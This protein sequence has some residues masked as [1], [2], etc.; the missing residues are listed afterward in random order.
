[1]PELRGTTE[2]RIVPLQGPLSTAWPP[3]CVTRKCSWQGEPSDGSSPYLWCAGD[4]A[5]HVR[6]P[7]GARFRTTAPAAAPVSVL[8]RPV[9]KATGL[10]RPVR[11]GP[12]RAATRAVVARIM[13]PLCGRPDTAVLEAGDGA[14][15]V[16]T[17]GP[18]GDR[19][20]QSEQPPP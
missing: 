18:L 7:V 10:R 12:P 19:C 8:P 15:T 6:A 4:P 11:S 16:M 20:R 5:R 14:R 17:H 3:T 13:C 2:P 9:P 1:M